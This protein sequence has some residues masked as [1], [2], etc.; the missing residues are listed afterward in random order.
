M[1]DLQQPIINWQVRSGDVDVGFAEQKILLIAQGNGTATPKELLE[2]VQPTEAKLLLGDGSMAERAYNRFREY[3][4]ANEIDI[5]TLAEPAGGANAQGAISVTGTALENKTIY[6]KIGDDEYEINVT[7][8]KDEVSS[9]IAVKIKDAINNSTFPFVA[10]IDAGDTGLVLI[11]FEFAGDLGNKLIAKKKNIKD[12]VSGVDFG[13][14]EFSGGAG[15]YDSA[16]IL[17]GIKTRYQTILFDECTNFDD[18]EDWL[19]ARVNMT[20]TVKGG[21]GFCMRN[22][23]YA[24]LKSFADSKN[25][26]TMTVFGNLDEMKYNAIPLLAVAE[27]GA[28]RALRL[29][30]GAVLGDLVLD[31]QESFGGINKSSLPY[32]N[33]PM[34][35]DKPN[36]E[37]IIEQ[38]QDLT[39]AGL[40]LF[41]P[42]TLGVV[43]GAVVTLYK[44][45]NSGIEDANFKYLNALDTSFAVQEYLFSNSQKEFGQTRATNGDLVEG[46]SMTNTLSVS[47]F[48]AGLYAD[49]VD[50][51]LVQGGADA[52]KS[53]KKTL[54]VTL[55]AQTGFYSVYSPV[56]IV[57][58]FRG[59]NGVV[60]I[61]YKFN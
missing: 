1:S 2:D 42:A 51:A 8:L 6:F 29:T 53:F 18:I 43:L 52:I 4:K 15:A 50:M 34:S 12:R 22:G 56:A 11:D 19:E 16:D 59:L 28:K 38:V 58:Q 26:K 23:D 5:I 54:N 14:T 61:S 32:H 7:I 45:D 17:S 60:P 35:Y 25:S 57:S 47:S 36:N 55:D 9:E 3:N 21:N 46:V 10:S 20:N 44:F 27:F 37:L 31:P 13:F 39:D 49:M 30:D 24:T 40:S 33:T 41:V 48:I